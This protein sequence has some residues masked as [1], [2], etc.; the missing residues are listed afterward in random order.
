MVRKA[1]DRHMTEIEA[2]R[3]EEEYALQTSVG[4]DEDSG[5]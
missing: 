3:R 4:D 1:L 5:G 2:G